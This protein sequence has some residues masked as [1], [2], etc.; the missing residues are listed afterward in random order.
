MGYLPQQSATP[1]PQGVSTSWRL[2]P[3]MSAVI[4]THLV[5]VSCD[6]HC[7]GVPT[8]SHGEAAGSTAPAPSVDEAVDTTQST[9]SP[10][11]EQTGDPLLLIGRDSSRRRQRDQQVVFLDMRSFQQPWLVAGAPCLRLVPLSVQNNLPASFHA[12]A[13]FL[14]NRWSSITFVFS[15]IG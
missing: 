11:F 3:A 15:L 5:K 4:A 7:T 2:L 8:P 9:G 6:R 1:A 14:R 13:A 12:L 10:T